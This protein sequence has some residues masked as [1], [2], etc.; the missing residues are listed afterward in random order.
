MA[1]NAT[2]SAE[3]N[4][5]EIFSRSEKFIEK[6]QKHILISIG[7]VILLV[8]AVLGIRH[9]YLIPKEKEAEAAIFR[10]EDYFAQNKYKIALEGDSAGYIGFEAIID[11]YG[12]TKTANLAKA[13]AG[14]CQYKMGNPEEALKYLKKFSADDKMISPAITG[15]IGDCYVDLNQVNEGIDYFKKA[16]S[17]ANNELL[18][19][20]FLKKAGIAYESL[21]EYKNAYDVYAQIKEKYPTSLEAATIE[22]Y[23][24][25]AQSFMK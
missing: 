4:V 9:A 7:I 20:I 16:A 8:V 1:T 25:R 17:K 3:K 22:K 21:K 23:M 14:I 2:N 13:Y 11:Q 15:L 6:Y 10:G 5:G 18:S 12:F 24:D 19:P